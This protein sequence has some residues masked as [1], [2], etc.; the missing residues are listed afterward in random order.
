MSDLKSKAKE[1]IDDAA[2]A[3]KATAGKAVDKG[4]DLTH[5]AGKKLESTGKSLRNV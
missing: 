2:A 3:A 4:K 5:A 1:K